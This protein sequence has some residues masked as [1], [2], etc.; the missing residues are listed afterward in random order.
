MK[1]DYEK[2]TYK[3]LIDSIKD[4]TNKY[5]KKTENN[6]YKTI[7]DK[8]NEYFRSIN[9]P[10]E[11]KAEPGL[12]Y[13]NTD[14]VNNRKMKKFVKLGKKTIISYKIEFKPDGRSR[15]RL[16]NY[17]NDI[18]ITNNLP[19]EFNDFTITNIIKVACYILAKENR[20]RCLREIK[21]LEKELMSYRQ[22]VYALEKE[23]KADCWD[24]EVFKND[25]KG[26]KI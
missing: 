4:I 21:E 14:E 9:L 6:A 26:E 1:N 17:I 24:E 8:I 2:N 18:T 5:I 10:S 11:L 16:T 22:G 7:S 23:M 13:I 20:D 19:E 3:Q 25:I 15:T 12:I